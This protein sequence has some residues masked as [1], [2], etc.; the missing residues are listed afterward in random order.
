MLKGTLFHHF[1]QVEK[2]GMFPAFKE[3]EPRSDDGLLGSFSC[4]EGTVEGD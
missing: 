1:Q 2:I 3:V 4:V